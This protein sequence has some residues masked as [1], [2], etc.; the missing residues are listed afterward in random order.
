MQEKN[1]QTAATPARPQA[2]LEPFPLVIPT[3]T[4]LE[5]NA[6]H[7]ELQRL[8]EKDFTQE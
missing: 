5:E 8:L 6:L 3:R 2:R 1:D 7:S 4:K